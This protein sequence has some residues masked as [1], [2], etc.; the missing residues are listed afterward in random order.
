MPIIFIF[1][2]FVLSVISARYAVIS[3]NSQVNRMTEEAQGTSSVVTPQPGHAT[4][5]GA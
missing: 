3:S 2:T 1:V 5:R 4:R